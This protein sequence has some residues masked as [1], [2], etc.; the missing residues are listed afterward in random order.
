MIFYVTSNHH[1]FNSAKE[2]LKNHNIVVE[3]KVIDIP[4]IQSDSIEEIAIEK[5]KMAFEEVKQPLFVNDSGW[6]IPALNG[7]PGPYMKYINNWFAPEDFISLMKNKTDRTSI[8]R[9]V[10]VYIDNGGLK[11]FENDSVGKILSQ[12]SKVQGRSSDMVVSFKDNLSV[13]EEKAKG[14]LNI[15]AE[16]QLWKDFANWLKENGK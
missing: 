1:K 8:L 9:Q 2:M 6:I 15:K 5:A 3:Q 11:I 10:I 12:P 4:E 14:I 7:F 16:L 13:S